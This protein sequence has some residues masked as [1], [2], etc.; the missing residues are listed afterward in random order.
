VP[1]GFIGPLAHVSVSLPRLG[2]YPGAGTRFTARI[3]PVRKVAKV[4]REPVGYRQFAALTEQI[5]EVNE[6][7]CEA[8]AG[9]WDHIWSKINNQACNALPADTRR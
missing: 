3:R 6:T 5:V 2:I 7:I 1:A 9:R 8:R 4:R